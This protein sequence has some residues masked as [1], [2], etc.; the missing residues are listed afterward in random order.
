METMV[1]TIAILLAMVGC[2]A[3]GIYVATQISNWI[4]KRLK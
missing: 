4:K 1:Y 3:M 2:F